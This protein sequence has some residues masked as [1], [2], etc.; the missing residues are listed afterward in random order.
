MLEHRP[1]VFYTAFTAEHQ[2][3]HKGDVTLFTRNGLIFR[4][5]SSVNRDGRLFLRVE[6][7]PR[8]SDNVRTAALVKVLDCRHLPDG[9]GFEV[10]VRYE[11]Q[12]F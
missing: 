11:P 6:N 2:E 12:Y 10:E 1:T 4:T 5:D 8:S 7:L 3:T 9:I